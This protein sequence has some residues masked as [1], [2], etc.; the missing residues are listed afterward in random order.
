MCTSLNRGNKGCEDAFNNTGEY[1]RSDCQASR[2]GR[3]GMFPATQCIKMVA[4]D[5][6]HKINA[7][8]KKN[9]NNSKIYRYYIVGCFW[10]VSFLCMCECF[11]VLGTKKVLLIGWESA[12][13]SLLPQTSEDKNNKVHVT[14]TVCQKKKEPVNK[15]D[16]SDNIPNRE[17]LTLESTV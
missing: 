8:Q 9:Y 11:S 15:M 16:S 17:A 7:S 4:E 10:R 14:F 6:K 2:E 5:S 12:H 13:Y 1:Y 3:I